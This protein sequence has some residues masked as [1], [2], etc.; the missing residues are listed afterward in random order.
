M[1]TIADLEEEQLR[2]HLI[3]GGYLNQFTDIFGNNQPSPTVQLFEV[4]FTSAT[5]DERIVMIR[6]MGGISNSS[7][8]TLYKERMMMIMVAGKSGESDSTITRGLADDMEK[9]L[10]A[11]HT[12]NGCIFNIVSSGVTGPLISDDSRRV[13]EINVIVSFNIN[14]PSFA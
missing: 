3:A 12:D 1:A 9:Y 2:L 5:P 10:M 14:R 11:N 4:D 6:T 13:Y 8:R 7:N